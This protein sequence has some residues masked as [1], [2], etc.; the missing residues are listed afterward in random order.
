MG[1]CMTFPDTVEEFMDSYKIVDTEHVY[2]NG[3]EMVP[4]FRMKQWF[5]HRP[6]R[7]TGKWKWSE[8]NASWCCSVCGC[9][10][11]EI[12]WKPEYNFCPNCGIRMEI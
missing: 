5:E 2:T 10:F 8:D 9:V 3:T 6:E 11:E 1:E 12:D 7:K 4:I